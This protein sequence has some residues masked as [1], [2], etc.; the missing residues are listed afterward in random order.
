MAGC[1]FEEL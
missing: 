1:L